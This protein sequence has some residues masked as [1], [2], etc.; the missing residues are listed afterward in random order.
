[1]VNVDA[2]IFA[3]SEK[4]GLGLVIRNHTGECLVAHNRLIDAVTD[5]EM[6]EA[7]AARAAVRFVLDEG[8]P[9]IHSGLGFPK[10]SA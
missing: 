5:P 8:F 6:A 1:M 3:E 10:P 9:E 7:V 4:T 2:A